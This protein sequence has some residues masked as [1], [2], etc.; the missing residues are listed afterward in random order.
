MNTQNNERLFDTEA[1]RDY[2]R[3]RYDKEG[4]YEAGRTYDDYEGRSRYTG[5]SFDEV[6]NDLRANWDTAKGK[7]QLAWDRAKQ[8]ARAAWDRV[9]RALPGDADRDGR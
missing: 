2:W 8:A 1:E 3:G 5:K 9:E 6:E 4:Y 7:S